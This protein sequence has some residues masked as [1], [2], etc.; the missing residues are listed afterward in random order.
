MQHSFSLCSL[1]ETALSDNQPH[2]LRDSDQPTLSQIFDDPQITQLD[3]DRV[4][5][6]RKSISIIDDLFLI[7][8]D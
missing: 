8:I 7:A 3:P 4:V 6:G 1:S 2:K 5:H